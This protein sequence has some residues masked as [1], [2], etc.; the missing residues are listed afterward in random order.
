MVVMPDAVLDK[1]VDANVGSGFGAAGERCLAGSVILAV[2]GVGP[3]L[4]EK[5]VSA[6]ARMKVGNG[7]DDGVEMGPV[8]SQKHKARVISYIERGLAES[9]QLLLD[10]RNIQVAGHPNGAFVGP[11]IFTNVR[12]EMAIANDEVFGP[13]LGVI[14][15]EN[16]DQALAIMDANPFGNA[17]AMSTQ[18][19]KW[20]REFRYR[21]QCGMVGINVGVPAPMGFFT[22]TGWKKSFF[23]DLHG[24]GRDAIEFFTEK[25]IM[26]SRWF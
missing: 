21:V 17:A 4:S 6:A 23:G 13:V 24:H 14:D 22:F 12:P 19:G 9:A 11:T 16:P 8:V 18:N 3:A 1:T 7:L 25:K 10:G 2:G 15:V 20:A 26:I 5:L